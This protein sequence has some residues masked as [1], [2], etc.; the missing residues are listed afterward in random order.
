MFK[1]LLFVFILFYTQNIL[2]QENIYPI[3]LVDIP[4]IFGVCEQF[5]DFQQKKCFEDTIKSHIQDNIVFPPEAFELGISGRVLVY[6]TV[7]SNGQI[8]E[9]QSRSPHEILKNEAERIIS[10]L[11][12]VN[13]AIKDQVAVKISYS[14]PVDFFLLSRPS[15]IDIQVF[16]GA[17]VYSEADNKS[18]IVAIVRNNSKWSGS[19]FGDYYMIDFI[20]SIGYISKED[21]SLQIDLKVDNKSKNDIVNIYETD[22]DKTDKIKKSNKDESYGEN[23]QTIT[24]DVKNET[25]ESSTTKTLISPVNISSKINDDTQ[26]KLN[27]NVI[28]KNK[29]N[30]N[31][32]NLV[33]K[34]E[35]P[36]T[37]YESINF[38]SVKQNFKS[39]RDKLN[40][41]KDKLEQQ[42]E[43][44]RKIEGVNQDDLYYTNAL[45][46]FVKLLNNNMDIKYQVLNTSFPN[47]FEGTKYEIKNLKLAK[48]KSKRFEGKL[49]KLT[50]SFFEKEFNSPPGNS[51]E[52]ELKEII[53]EISQL[54][55]VDIEEVKFE[56]VVSVKE[57]IDNENRNKLSLRE[58]NETNSKKPSLKEDKKINEITENYSEA[59][60]YKL[61]RNEIEVNKSQ[62]VE[63]SSNDQSEIKEE[64]EEVKEMISEMRVIIQ[65][66]N[67]I[68]STKELTKT[69]E[70][71]I[72][73]NINDLAED[74]ISGNISQEDFF[75][76]LKLLDETK[77]N[78]ELQSSINNLK[79]LDEFLNLN[80]LTQSIKMK[81]ELLKSISEVNKEAKKAEN[82]YVKSEKY[83]CS[84]FTSFNYSGGRQN[85]VSANKFE[86]INNSDKI[87][88]YPILGSS[89]S[90]ILFNVKV[91]GS[92]I[93]FDSDSKILI[94]FRDGSR[95]E[96]SHES[97]DN[98]DGETVVF[99]GRIFGEKAFQDLNEL[100]Y[101]EV[102]SIRIWMKNSLKEVTLSRVQS[103]QLMFTI[104][105]LSSYMI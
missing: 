80:I 82:D 99:L 84:D 44:N 66:K 73:L 101:K 21:T 9:I 3:S 13:P 8:G 54:E 95:T 36:V 48:K 51:K 98:C 24:E 81:S 41:Y 2:S 83:A 64:L 67:E 79:S 71:K 92:D 93:C 100:K 42:K 76:K 5:N 103:Q 96:I 63:T 72:K 56:Q 25:Y 18:E 33:V 35:M 88:I 43:I 7:D 32:E 55:Y 97:Y 49:I 59:N 17:N 47:V 61:S 50:K 65:E 105:C 31:N 53:A 23:I 46:E 52:N 57:N 37:V 68:N 40:L 70:N 38:N 69:N 28:E 15:S 91:D 14:L 60:N 78:S 29:S 10:I 27:T 16:A 4:P 77:D 34:V 20:T 75:N 22:F 94:T 58:Q 86:I 90:S 19:S 12:S 1:R 102:E 30:V 45:K 74:L 6:F 62:V 11:P 104:D 39:D 89:K 26:Y 87:S 85:I